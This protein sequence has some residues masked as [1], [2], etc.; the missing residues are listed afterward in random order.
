MRSCSEYKN[1]ALKS[2]SDNWGICI[3]ATLILMVVEVCMAYVFPLILVA[4]PIEFGLTVIYLNL[5][6]RTQP[7]MKDL[8]TG[9]QDYGRVFLTLL[10]RD[11]YSLL[12]SLLLVVP[13]IVKMYSYAM[14]PYLM[15]EDPNLKYDAAISAS[16]RMMKGHKA[17][18]FWLHLSFIG[19]IVLC[20][21]TCGIG[22]LFLAPYMNAAQAHFYEDLK[23]EQ[24]A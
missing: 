23:A 22:F 21:L 3:L 18:L 19:W 12:W 14:T 15:I 10:L 5:V 16:S 4:L 7:T 20:W 9:F 24:G 6:W 8:F 1:L 13:G 2:L 17:E 11:V